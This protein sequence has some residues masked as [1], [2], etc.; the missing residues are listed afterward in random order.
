MLDYV[1]GPLARISPTEAVVDVAGL[2]YLLNLSL[3]NL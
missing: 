3:I 2:G 1:S